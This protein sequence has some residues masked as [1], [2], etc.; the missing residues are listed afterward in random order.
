MW[1]LVPR[2]SN[3]NVIGTKWIFKNKT[4]ELGNI[5][6]N[7]ARLVAQGYTQVEGVDFDE[8][9]AP[10]A[11]L[12]S[13]QLLLSIACLMGFKLFQID[14]KSG[15]TNDFLNEKVFVE[16]PKGFEDPQHPDHVYKLKKAL[17]GLKQAPRTWYK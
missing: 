3:S 12:E 17:Y 16:Q 5:T 2:L 1:D 11:K 15:F 13:I 4:N 6:R 14:V 10:V 7:K 8:M 9:F